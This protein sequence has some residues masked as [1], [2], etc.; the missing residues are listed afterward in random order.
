MITLAKDIA[1]LGQGSVFI[2]D[3]TGNESNYSV[4]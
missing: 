1:R 4:G 2:I 3:V